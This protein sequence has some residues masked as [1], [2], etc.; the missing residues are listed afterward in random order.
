MSV[1]ALIEYRAVSRSA[2]GGV[3]VENGDENEEGNSI[4]GRFLLFRASPSTDAISDGERT[5]RP[6]ARRRAWWTPAIRA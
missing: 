1:L 6:R 3:L 4:I 2:R 5:G